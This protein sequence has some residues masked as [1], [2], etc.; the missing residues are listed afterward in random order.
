MCKILTAVLLLGLIGCSTP[1]R[2]K[3][4]DRIVY[5]TKPRLYKTKAEKKQ[6]CIVFFIEKGVEPLDANT[7][8]KP[9]L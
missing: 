9:S 3:Y 1:V 8:C 4:R 7:I 2:Y 6:D 5:K